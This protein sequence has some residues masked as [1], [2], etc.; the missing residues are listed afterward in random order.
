MVL[1]T[2]I[3]FRCMS[4]VNK[5]RI[6]NTVALFGSAICFIAVGFVPN[7]LAWLS[8]AITTLNYAF[9]GANCGGFYKC[10]ALV[11]RL[12][13]FLNSKIVTIFQTVC[14]FRSR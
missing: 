4:E 12:S 5:M 7:E 10:G 8:V 11:A 2:L 14:L 3:T 1:K 6:C 9:I 13:R